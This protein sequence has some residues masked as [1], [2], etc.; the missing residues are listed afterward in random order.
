[1]QINSSTAKVGQQ[2][3]MGCLIINKIEQILAVSWDIVGR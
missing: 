2:D 1:M 3:F